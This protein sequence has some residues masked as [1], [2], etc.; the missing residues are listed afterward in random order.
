MLANGHRRHQ[1]SVGLSLPNPP[2]TNHTRTNDKIPG[3]LHKSQNRRY[4]S[5]LASGTKKFDVGE[6]LDYSSDVSCAVD[7][8]LVLTSNSALSWKPFRIHTAVR[9]PSLLSCYF[10]KFLE[11]ATSS[12]T[13]QLIF[14]L[15]WPSSSTW[16]I[17]AIDM[18][19]QSASATSDRNRVESLWGSRAM[20]QPS[21]SNTQRLRTEVYRVVKLA[22][23]HRIAANGVF[24]IDLC[25][26]PVP[27][28]LLV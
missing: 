14:C 23:V 3:S 17:S 18:S 24:R 6:N 10:L 21:N 1:T 13:S 26:A 9:L 27:S 4:L 22:V 8:T 28:N 2:R 7:L 15:A 16:N 25:E 19:L 12:Q 20:N 11:I 5:T